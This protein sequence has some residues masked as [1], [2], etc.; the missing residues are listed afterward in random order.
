MYGTADKMRIV[1][2]MMDGA[3]VDFRFITN[4]QTVRTEH[5]TVTVLG[6]RGLTGPS[7]QATYGAVA[8][9]NARSDAVRWALCR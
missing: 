6:Y 7:G 1:R 2:D 3:G 5:R 8:N 9:P 4:P